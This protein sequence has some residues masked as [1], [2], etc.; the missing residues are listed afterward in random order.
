MPAKL[1]SCGVAELRRPARGPICKSRRRCSR[2]STGEN[3][4]IRRNFY[5]HPKPDVNGWLFLGLDRSG[6]GAK[7][8]GGQF[9]SV[10]NR[11]KI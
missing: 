9:R 2:P 5:G 1:Q 7:Y 6:T 8:R 4:L 10:A 3:F 11:S